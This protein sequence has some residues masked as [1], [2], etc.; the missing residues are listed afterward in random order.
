MQI[1]A[2]LDMLRR[3]KSP[4]K[5]QERWCERISCSIEGIL[6]LS[7][8]SQ[9]SHPRK[10]I[11]RKEG[12]IGIESRR[13]ILQEHVRRIQI[14]ERKGPPRGII[15]KCE[16]HERSPG[17]PRLEERSQ[18]ETLQQER[19]GRKASWDLARIFTSS[20]VQT[21]LRFTVLLKQG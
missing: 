6:P 10:S 4:A 2:V 9:D 8:V 5:S 17:A 7:S 18:D 11:L 16:P 19:C 1:D 13:Q 3:K 21:K 20:K 15:Q 14:R 12:K